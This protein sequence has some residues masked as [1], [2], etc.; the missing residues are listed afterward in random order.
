[1]I[2]RS[3]YFGFKT[4]TVADL[5]EFPERGHRYSHLLNTLLVF[6]IAHDFSPLLFLKINVSSRRWKIRI[7]QVFSVS[8]AVSKS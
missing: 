6:E 8:T 2:F 7:F 3:V 1:M 5:F 4:L